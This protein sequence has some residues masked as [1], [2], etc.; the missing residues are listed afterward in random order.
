VVIILRWFSLIR[1]AILLLYTLNISLFAR[2]SEFLAVNATSYAIPNWLIEYLYEEQILHSK[3]LFEK[4]LFDVNID[5]GYLPENAPI[6]ALPYY[7]IPGEEAE[8]LQSKS[9]D[10]MVYKEIT[11]VLEGKTFYKLFVHPESE[12]HYSVLRSKYRY[13]SPQETEFLASPTSSYRSLVV[14]NS[15]GSCEKPFIAKVSLDKNILGHNRILS[16][17]EIRVSIANQL[18]F[19]DFDKKRSVR[20]SG[21]DFFPE[22]AG[23]ILKTSENNFF[24]QLGGQ[25]IREFSDKMTKE[26]KKWISFASLMSPKRT[27]PLVMEV[28]KKSGLSS[29]DFIREYLID[30][31]L[32]FFKNVILKNGI[33]DLPHSQNLGFETTSDYMPTGIFIIKDLSDVM[34]D[35]I[36]HLGDSDILD[37][38]S[39][40]TDKNLNK[41]RDR[42]VINFTYHYKEQVFD[43]LLEEIAKHDEKIS[44]WKLHKLRSELEEK[45]LAVLNEH[46]GFKHGVYKNIQKQLMH[47]V[48]ID[49]DFFDRTKGNILET[50]NSSRWH[51]FIREKYLKKRLINYSA[52]I[53]EVFDMNNKL[54]INQNVLF[55][56]KEKR[57]IAMIILTLEDRARINLIDSGLSKFFN[58]H[59][60]HACQSFFEEK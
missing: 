24:Q 10:L 6:F 2:N 29:E 49:K 53:S 41:A 5:E 54:F 52:S 42:G 15:Q 39:E 60:K 28:I 30:K 31:Y 20:E 26:Q 4:G 1:I 40:V 43:L 8:F 9:H 32:N 35:F 57:F 18:F 46:F 7:L 59:K 50:S 44:W 48:E 45:H 22:T 16:D 23:L 58:D 37:L 56:V 51:G 25:I 21:F 12:A 34:P 19:E 47:K 3:D 14:W 11:S 55:I 36:E 33:Y 27:V 13:I 38:Y 17:E